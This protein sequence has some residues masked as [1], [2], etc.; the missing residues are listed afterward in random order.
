MRA[1]AAGALL[2]LA[3]CAG[4]VGT[5]PLLDVEAQAD[6]SVLRL[7]TVCAR[8]L[9]ARV[10][11]AETEIV[12]ILD[13]DR[14]DDDCIGTVLVTLAAPAGTRFVRDG[15][16]GTVFGRDGDRYLRLTGDS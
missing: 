14:L 4:G 2:A 7:S 9:T 5:M 16:A 10:V 13:G 1:A 11:E 15:A 3:A 8:N 12:V 6:P